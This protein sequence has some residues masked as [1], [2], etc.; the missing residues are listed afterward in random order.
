MA[1][2]TESEAVFTARLKALGIESLQLLFNGKGWKTMSTFAFASSWTPG[3]GDDTAFRQKVLMPLLGS[4]D[5]IDVTKIRKLYF[6]CYT[7]VA[8]ELR[9]KLDSGAEDSSKV[10]KLPVAG[11]QVEVGGREGKI[12]PHEL[13]C[14]RHGAS[15][16]S[17]R[18]VPHH[19]V[20]R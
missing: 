7:L 4:E 11:A 9:S 17:G 1:S 2:L 12:S 5:H 20:G 16:L 15:T 10:R 6:E 13:Q 14:R 18:Q 3:V 19:E 8:A